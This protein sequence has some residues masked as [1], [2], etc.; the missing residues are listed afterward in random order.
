MIARI[1]PFSALEGLSR[2][3]FLVGSGAILSATAVDGGASGTG[4]RP[5]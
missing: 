4:R 5:G 1:D 3:R 2:R